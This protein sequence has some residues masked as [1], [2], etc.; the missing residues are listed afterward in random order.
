MTIKL[1]SKNMADRILSLFGKERAVF[2][3]SPTEK[4]DDP[5]IY[6]QIRK[7]SFFKALLRPK[8]RSLPDG[9][10]YL[11][12]FDEKRENTESGDTQ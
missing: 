10:M 4:C 7:E 5:Y 3:P 12:D 8:N 2:I 1:P 6:L 11:S 9:L